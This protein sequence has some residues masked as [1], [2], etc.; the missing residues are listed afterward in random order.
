MLR[1]LVVALL[2]ANALFVVWSRGGFAGVAGI[3]SP[4]PAE[5]ER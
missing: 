1:L 4:N 5:A 3:P 2:L